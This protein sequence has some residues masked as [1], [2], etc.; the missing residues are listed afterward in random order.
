MKHC[1][2]FKENPK[3]VQGYIIIAA[4]NSENPFYS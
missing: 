4:K 2:G 1:R 3:D